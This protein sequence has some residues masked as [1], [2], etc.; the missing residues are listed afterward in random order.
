MASF[1][2]IV[3]SMVLQIFEVSQRLAPFG[4]HPTPMLFLAKGKRADA[5]SLGIFGKD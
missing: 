3:P 2:L 1:E 4:G 5:G